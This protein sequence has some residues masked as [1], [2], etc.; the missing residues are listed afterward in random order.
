MLIEICG[1]IASGKTTLCNGIATLGYNAVFEDFQKNPFL[2]YFYKDHIRFSFETEITFLLQHYSA[3]KVALNSCPTIYDFSLIQDLAYADINL[4]GKRK[5][6]FYD[7]ENELRTEIGHP[8]ILLYISCPPSVLLE[9]IR[10]R[11]RAAERSITLDYL[12]KLHVALENRVQMVSTNTL[13]MNIDSSKIDFRNNLS[14]LP[15]LKNFI[16]A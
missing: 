5:S 9:R 8:D 11:N 7:L 14:Q 1:G 3:I 16:R 10:T 4:S 13:L 6:I 2:E 15:I 12:E